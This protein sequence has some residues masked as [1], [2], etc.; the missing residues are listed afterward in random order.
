[1]TLVRFYVYE[2]KKCHK[3]IHTYIEKDKCIKCGYDWEVE[4]YFDLSFPNALYEDVE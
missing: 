3:Y 4:D 1:M 2:C